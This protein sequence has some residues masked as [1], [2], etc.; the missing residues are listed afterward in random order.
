MTAGSQDLA[1]KRARASEAEEAA[2][3]LAI[4]AEE[5]WLAT[6]PPVDVAER[7]R[8]LRDAI[9]GE[10]P[11]ALWLLRDGERTVG[12]LGLHSTGIPGVASLGMAV[13]EEHRG[14]GGGRALVDAALEY[15]RDAGLRK[16]ELEVFPD[17]GRAIALYLGAGF[18]IEGYRRDHYVRRDGSVRSSVLMA[19]LLAR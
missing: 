6:E 13:L 11:D 18:E 4:V 7:A 5:G 19:R 15:A 2:L 17:N 3:V 12:C 10:G 1:V 8:R 16:L 9:E 14:R